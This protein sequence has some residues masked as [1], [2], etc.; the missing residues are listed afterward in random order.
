MTPKE[1]ASELFNSMK[2]FRVK[3]SHSLKCA[4]NTVDEIL[5]EIKGI[6]FNHDLDVQ[7]LT[8]YWDGVKVELENLKKSSK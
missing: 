1:K 4:T 3:H 6:E 7:N 5:K 2:G 8:D